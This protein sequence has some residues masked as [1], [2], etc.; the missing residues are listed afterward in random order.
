MW[1]KYDGLM[2]S[3]YSLGN[4]SNAINWGKKALDEAEKEFGMIDS[5]YATPLNN[6]A[7]VY[8]LMGRYAEAEP[9]HVQSMKIRKMVLGLKHVDATEPSDEYFLREQTFA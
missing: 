9:L 7:E 4:Y 8:R 6:L 3:S 1:E 5:K 2:E